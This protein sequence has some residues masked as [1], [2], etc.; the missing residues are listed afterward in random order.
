M[1]TALV[2]YYYNNCGGFSDKEREEKDKKYLEELKNLSKSNAKKIIKIQ[3]FH[4]G[5]QGSYQDG[6]FESAT[7]VIDQRLF[8][9]KNC[10]EWVEKNYPKLK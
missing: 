7:D 10:R 2:D 4:Y 8:W 5:R 1:I 9:V 3:L 6:F